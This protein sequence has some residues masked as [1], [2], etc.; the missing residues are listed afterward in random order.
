M[1]PRGSLLPRSDIQV[2]SLISQG[3]VITA[4]FGKIT[5]LGTRPP[6]PSIST[7]ID[8]EQHSDTISSVAFCGLS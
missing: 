3:E 1:F 2:I 7:D 4:E 8:V 5:K 6:T